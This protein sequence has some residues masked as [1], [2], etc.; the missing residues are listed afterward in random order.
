MIEV[1]AGTTPLLISLPH[2][3]QAVP[4]DLAARMTPEALAVA[5]TD[6]HVEHLYAFARHAGAAWLQPR[7]SRYVVDLN[8]PPDD[9]ALYPGQLSTGLCPAQAFDGSALYRDG[10]PDGAEIAVRRDR[11][12]APY[13][14]AL[15]DLLDAAIER[16]GFAVLLDAHSIRSEV[17][18]LFD[19]R[20][21]DINVG[22]HGGISCAP[23]LSGAVMAELATQDR[24]TC[25]LDGRFK[26][27]YI[28]RHYGAPDDDVHA[29]QIELAQ[30]AYMDEAGTAY[31]A[32]RAAALIGVL[33][34]VVS[35]LLAFQP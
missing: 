2:V 9:A 16:H 19:G 15:R 30:S 24:F 25:V 23:S 20:L 12:W 26:G 17:P 10:G 27:G 4:D 18:R 22:T 29:L 34:R 3:G 33:S 7:W 6:W 32:A 21:P 8:R 13:H 11:Y 31:D 14:Q 35:A 28:T 1:H 5:D